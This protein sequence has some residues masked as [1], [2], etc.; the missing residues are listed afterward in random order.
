MKQLPEELYLRKEMLLREEQILRD[1][2]ALRFRQLQQARKEEYRKLG[3]TPPTTQEDKRTFW[4]C[5]P[6]LLLL[7]VLWFCYLHQ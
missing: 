4:V 1:R 3:L 2:T 5:L 7:A 6:I